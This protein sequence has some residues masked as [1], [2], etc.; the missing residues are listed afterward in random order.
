MCNRITLFFKFIPVYSKTVLTWAL[1]K[2][3]LNYSQ[4]TTRVGTAKE[5]LMD[6]CIRTW[7][8]LLY[9]LLYSSNIYSE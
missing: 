6:T 2:L 3:A 5:S 1:S 9:M 7:V 8:K 4:I